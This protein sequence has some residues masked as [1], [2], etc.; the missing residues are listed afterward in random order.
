MDVTGAI[1]FRMGQSKGRLWLY[2]WTFGINNMLG[3]YWL[4]WLSAS[5]KIVPNAVFS[6][7][8]TQIKWVCRCK[9]IYCSANWVIYLFFKESLLTAVP[10]EN[11]S[12]NSDTTSD[13]VPIIWTNKMHYF[14]LIY[15]NNKLPQVSSRFVA[16]HQEVQLYI[17]SNRYSHVLRW[18]AAVK[19]HS[20]DTKIF[21]SK[22]RNLFASTFCCQECVKPWVD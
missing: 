16:R 20:Q 1:W 10:T 2:Q 4:M 3:M 15:F 22:L 18:L 12:F 6:K 21:L 7:F 11:A 9:R 19:F 14:L 17:N 5:Q 13:F 8:N